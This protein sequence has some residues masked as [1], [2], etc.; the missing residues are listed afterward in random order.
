MDAAAR[1]TF[2]PPGGFRFA[3]QMLRK[4]LGR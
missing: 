2:S 3:G 1:G 4:S